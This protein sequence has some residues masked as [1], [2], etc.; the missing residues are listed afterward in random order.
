MALDVEVNQV[1][2]DDC[3]FVLRFMVV[4]KVGCS[5][6]CGQLLNSSQVFVGQQGLLLL[7]GFRL[8]FG[9]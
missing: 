2:I 9:G 7:V 5:A 8:S 6:A 4:W 3:A 1:E